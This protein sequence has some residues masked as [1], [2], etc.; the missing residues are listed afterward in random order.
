M[1]VASISNFTAPPAKLWATVPDVAK[2]LLLSNV[3]CSKCRNEISIKTFTGKQF[4][5]ARYAPN[6]LVAPAKT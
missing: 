2:Q 6:F 3:W 5:S 1:N 4:H